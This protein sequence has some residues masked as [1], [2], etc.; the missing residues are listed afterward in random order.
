M[1]V[2]WGQSRESDKS[3]SHPGLELHQGKVEMYLKTFTFL[4]SGA[5]DQIMFKRYMNSKSC[6]I[7]HAVF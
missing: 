2:S 7:K 1:S 4:S 3:V 5:N 6:T